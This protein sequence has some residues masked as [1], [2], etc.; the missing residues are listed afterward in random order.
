MN[1]TETKISQHGVVDPF[2]HLRPRCAALQVAHKALTG[3]GMEFG[4]DDS[5]GKSLY[6]KVFDQFVSDGINAYG[7]VDGQVEGVGCGKINT[8]LQVFAKPWPHTQNGTVRVPGK[9]FDGKPV[10]AYVA[11]VMLDETGK[12]MLLDRQGTVVPPVNILTIETSE[13]QQHH[14]VFDPASTCGNQRFGF[15]LV[16][17]EEVTQF[18]VD[19]SVSAGV[20]KPDKGDFQTVMCNGMLLAHQREPDGINM[21]EWRFDTTTRAAAVSRTVRLR[22]QLVGSR[23]RVNAAG[24]D[25]YEGLDTIPLHYLHFLQSFFNGSEYQ[26]SKC[27]GV[28]RAH[29]KTGEVHKDD[30]Y[31][32]HDSRFMGVHTAS[33][34]MDVTVHLTLGVVQYD[35]V[36]RPVEAAAEVDL[37]HN[38]EGFPV[39]LGQARQ[40]GRCFFDGSRTFYCGRMLGQTAIPGSDGQCGPTN[41]PACES[42]RRFTAGHVQTLLSCLQGDKNPHARHILENTLKIG[43]KHVAICTRV[44]VETADNYGQVIP[45][46]DTIRYAGEPRKLAYNASVNKELKCTVFVFN[47]EHGGNEPLQLSPIYVVQTDTNTFSEE[48]IETFFLYDGECCQIPMQLYHDVAEEPDGFFLVD[49]KSREKIE[50]LFHSKHILCMDP[51]LLDFMNEIGLDESAA[52]IVQTYGFKTLAEVQAVE[53]VEIDDMLQDK[54]HGLGNC[55]PRFKNAFKRK[56]MEIAAEAAKRAKH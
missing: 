36:T 52:V 51:L 3:A 41:G 30:V 43:E 34:S 7:L 47:I 38:D 35:A 8:V 49:K 42:C 23:G 29:I 31:R 50:I 28:I 55:Q 16:T 37:L 46:R 44:G 53:L 27:E 12:H 33:D 40:V 17:K 54:T 11:L 2:A 4:C 1:E 9:Y 25:G 21:I 24:L 18:G 26:N 39:A 13:G 15:L 6:Q 20:E 10:P 22:M 19:V 45:M 5:T 14:A 48:K 32:N 56:L